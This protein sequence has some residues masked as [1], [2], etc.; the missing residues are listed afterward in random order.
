M[1]KILL[2]KKPSQKIILVLKRDIFSKKKKKKFLQIC[3]NL[4]ILQALPGPHHSHHNLKISNIN[5]YNSSMPLFKT[6]SIAL[7]EILY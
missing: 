7:K 4:C 2:W 1:R 3:R 6:A 5:P